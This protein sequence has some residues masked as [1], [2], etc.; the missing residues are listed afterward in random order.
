MEVL[1]NIGLVTSISDIGEAELDL[2]SR[3]GVLCANRGLALISVIDSDSS[4][5]CSFLLG[6]LVAVP[7]SLLPTTFNVV[8]DSRLPLEFVFFET[9]ESDVSIASAIS[10]MSE[11]LANI[12]HSPLCLLGGFLKINVVTVS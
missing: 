10:L 2:P 4:G 11:S 8:I 12:F 5:F 6:V 1:T 9:G 7:D 3:S